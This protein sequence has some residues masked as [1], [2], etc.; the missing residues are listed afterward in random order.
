MSL[1]ARIAK[2]VTAGDA[3][4]AWGEGGADG[5]SDGGW[6]SADEELRYADGEEEEEEVVEMDEAD[7]MALLDADTPPLLVCQRLFRH[8]PPPPDA[9]QLL[10]GAHAN[11]SALRARSC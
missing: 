8:P 5:F 3:A 11:A 10:P 4:P 7:V 6:S 9:L 2:V 1:E